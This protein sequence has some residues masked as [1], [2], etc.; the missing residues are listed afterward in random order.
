MTSIIL[1]CT[2]IIAAQVIAVTPSR[3]HH[4][5]AAYFLIAAGLPILVFVWIENGWLLAAI[6]MVAGMSVLR[7]PVFYAYKW[8]RRI[9]GI[10]RET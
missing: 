2:W 1:A 3:D 10:S 4:W 9:L 8:V 5:R 6:A 7:W